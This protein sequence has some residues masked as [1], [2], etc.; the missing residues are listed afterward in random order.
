MQDFAQSITYIAN[1][2]Q[3]SSFYI[4]NCTTNTIGYI[5]SQPS[6]IW[7]IWTLWSVC[8]KKCEIKGGGQEMVAMVGYNG[9]FLIMTIQM[10]LCAL[11][12]SLRLGT[13]IFIVK[14]I[15][16]SQPSS[17]LIYIF[18]LPW[19]YIIKAAHFF[20]VKLFCIDFTFCCCIMCIMHP[21]WSMANL[22]TFSSMDLCFP[23]STLYSGTSIIRMSIIW[24]VNCLSHS[25]D[26]MGL[27]V[28]KNGWA[29][30]YS[31]KAAEV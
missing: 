23:G 29:H 2:T 3:I 27:S 9:N 28:S 17:P 1:V 19:L 22:D 10:N 20:T 4:K 5:L 18:F 6:S 30:G 21:V 15:L 11:Q 24:N 7:R 8:S 31:L 16:P 12:V 26:I 25:H 14:I 13:W